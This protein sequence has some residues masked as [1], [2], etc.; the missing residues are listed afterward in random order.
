MADISQFI[1]KYQKYNSTFKA[2]SLDDS[3]NISVCTDKSQSVIN[4]DKIIELKYPNSNTRPK[5]FDAIYIYE[6]KIFC[7]EFKNQKPSD[8]RNLE[9]EEKLQN[10]INELIKIFANLNI[11]KKRYN[12]VFCVAYKRC[13]EPID[14]Y[15]CG[16]GKNSVLFG[17]D[18]CKHKNPISDIFTENVDFFT[19]QFKNLTKKELTC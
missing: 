1:N 15:K 3:N 9:I 16:I 4:F 6:D 17:L 14:R 2:T 11:Q 18:K 5:S 10:G 19:K 7:I 8:I 13:K 12:F